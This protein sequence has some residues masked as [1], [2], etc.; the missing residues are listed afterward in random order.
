MTDT[1]VTSSDLMSPQT[2]PQ[3]ETTQGQREAAFATLQRLRSDA[4]FKEKYLRRDD[5][6]VKAVEEAHRLTTTPTKLTVR[7]RPVEE[8]ASMI[9]AIENFSSLAPEVVEQLKS[10]APVSAEEQKWAKQ[11]KSQLMQDKAWV[12][13]YLDGDRAERQQ[14]ILLNAI[15]TSPTSRK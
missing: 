7:G 11:R 5:A 6:T 15:L 3:L 2:A 4:D 1:P 14:M 13:K 8:V 9:G 12:T 10:G